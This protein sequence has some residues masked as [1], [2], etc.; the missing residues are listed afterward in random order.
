MSVMPSEKRRRLPFLEQLLIELLPDFLDQLLD[1]R[2]VNA[3]VLHQAL[4]RDA[5][6]LAAD[7]IE[8]GEDH[9]FRRVIDDEVDAGG[10]LQRADVASF[11][12]DDPSLHVF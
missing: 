8:A 10:K 9:R 7:R 3:P 1:A 6:D 2:R 4:E 5:C 12:A 11:A